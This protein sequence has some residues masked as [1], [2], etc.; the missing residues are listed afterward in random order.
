MKRKI[1]L[2]DEEITIF[3]VYNFPYD[4]I[5]LDMQRKGNN[6]RSKYKFRLEFGTFDIETTSHI[7]SMANGVL[8]GY[9]YM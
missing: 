1:H 3:D 6:S 9:G 7:N 4:Q 2:G 5:K 8:D